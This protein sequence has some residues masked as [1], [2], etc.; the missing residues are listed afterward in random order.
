MKGAGFCVMIPEQSLGPNKMDVTFTDHLLTCAPATN[1]ISLSA[2]RS[3][4]TI[5]VYETPNSY[6]QMMLA[7]V[8][9]QQTIFP[10]F[11]ET[12]N[13]TDNVGYCLIAAGG[14]AHRREE[15]PA[16]Q[17]GEP[18]HVRM[19]DQGPASSSEDMRPELHPQRQL[20][21]PHPTQQWRVDGGRPGLR[22]SSGCFWRALPPGFQQYTTFPRFID[23]SAS[24]FSPN[25]LLTRLLCL[26]GTRTVVV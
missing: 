13:V 8:L 1:N 2:V 20:R 12:S 3:A 4:I 9:L 24:F 18:R 26:Q 5:S 23:A 14:H 11:S 22:G 6:R 7:T 17:A 10:T 21:E 15:D 19:G 25:V 16:F